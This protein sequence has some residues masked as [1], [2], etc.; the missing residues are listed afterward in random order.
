[1]SYRTIIFL[2]AVLPIR[3]SWI[4]FTDSK[5]VDARMQD[6]LTNLPLLAKQNE[7]TVIVPA[8]DV[9]LTQ[10]ELPKLNRQRL[11]QAL[12]FALEEQLIDDV[13]ELHFAIADYQDGK[14]PVAIVAR[15]KMNEWLAELKELGIQ[16]SRLLS[17]VFALPFIEKNWTA[18]I[19]AEM[20]AIRTEKYSG[21]ASDPS[22]LAL[23]IDLTLKN[24]VEKPTCIHIYNTLGAS[25]ALNT[26]SILQNDI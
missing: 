21:F 3:A 15:K 11:M 9:L 17:A 25:I 19:T 8:D 23:M 20:S 16:P 1:M 18:C 4:F 12:P 24:A 26:D 22:N 14:I 13:S 6:D 5:Q 7:I 2:Q 10:A